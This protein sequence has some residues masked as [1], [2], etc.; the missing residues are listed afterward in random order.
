RQ[1]GDLERDA[2]L[3]AD[4][5]AER[6]TLPRVLGAQ[7]EARLNTPDG[8]GRDRDP[9]V[10]EGGEELCEAAT[11]LTEQMILGY[12]RIVEG[13]R[14]RVGAVPAEL[15]VRG[16]DDEAGRARR[17]QDRGDLRLAVGTFP[18]TRRHGHDRR[19]R[20]AGVGDELL[21]TV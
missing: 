11:P 13:E 7:V 6:R 5:Y 21:R 1:V 17:H 12:A 3:G 2:L 16:L 20:R 19:D 14:M 18:R 15:V 10:V 4:G 8:E 9:A